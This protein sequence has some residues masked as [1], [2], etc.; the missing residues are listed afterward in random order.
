MSFRHRPHLRIAPAPW[1]HVLI[2][3]VTLSLLA[4]GLTACGGDG[5]DIAPAVLA[6]VNGEA[7][8]QAEVD[9]VRAEARLA[10]DETDADAALDEAIGRELVRQEAARLGLS[11]DEAAVDERLADVTERAGGDEA[12]TKALGEAGMSA[13][14]L[15]RGAEYGLL[16]GLLRDERFGDVAVGDAKVRAFYHRYADELFTEPAAADLSSLLVRT[17]RLA[18]DI[19]KDLRAGE[20]FADLAKT[21]SRDPVSRNAGGRLGWTTLASLPDPLRQAVTK[22]REGEVAGP[23]QGPGGWFVLKLHDRRAEAVTAFAEVEDELR[24]ELDLRARVRAL[25]RWIAA[26]RRRADVVPTAP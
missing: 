12:L 19:V 5:D 8:T 13:D 14:Q 22:M 15:R 1:W 11:V 9:D 17:E 25:D 18:E 2:V 26:E 3:V 24:A 10:G 7:V 20:P 16:R 23:V 4:G 6:R 21:Y